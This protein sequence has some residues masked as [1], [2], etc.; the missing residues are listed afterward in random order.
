MTIPDPLMMTRIAVAVG[1]TV[2][3]LSVAAVDDAR[4]ATV[5]LDVNAA[6]VLSE[7]AVAFA[8]YR[9][10]KSGFDQAIGH[11]NPFA[12]ANNSSLDG[13]NSLNLSNAACDFSLIH[14]AGSGYTFLLSKPGTTKYR[15]L[16]LGHRCGRHADADAIV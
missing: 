16:H 9:F 5:A 6:D 11:D 1:V 15:C 7:S 10:G 13:G 4:A 3:G 8:R 2:L 14:T 12:V